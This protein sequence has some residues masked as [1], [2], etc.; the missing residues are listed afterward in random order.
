M[1]RLHWKEFEQ[2]ATRYFEQEFERELVREKKRRVGHEQFHKFDA[3][4]TDGDIIIECKNYTWVNGED[5][6]PAKISNLNET[7]LFLSRVDAERKLIVLQDDFRG[8]DEKSLAEYYVEHYGGLMD[9][10]EVWSY[11]PKD[12]IKD[13]KVTQVREAAEYY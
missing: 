7:L 8:S 11:V 1:E 6:P 2:R 4:S 12:S 5:P 10:V 3:V 13:D 9:E